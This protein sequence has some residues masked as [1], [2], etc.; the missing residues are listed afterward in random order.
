M[1][2]AQTQVDIQEYRDNR[3]DCIYENICD[4]NI[5][6][7]LNEQIEYTFFEGSAYYSDFSTSIFDTRYYEVFKGCFNWDFCLENIEGVREVY[8][9]I[10]HRYLDYFIDI[11]VFRV[12]TFNI[13]SWFIRRYE[14]EREYIN[15]LKKA[16]KARLKREQKEVNE[17]RLLEELKQK[18]EGQQQI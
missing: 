16:E 7:E 8:D 9:D 4:I 18:Y 15:R 3:L 1:S 6:H 14:T 13:A 2:R 10:R 12:G 11:P 17:R 5:L